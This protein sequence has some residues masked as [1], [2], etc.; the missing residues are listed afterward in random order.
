MVS[1]VEE[2][3]EE[4]DVP[5]HLAR[6]AV[7]GVDDEGD[8]AQAQQEGRDQTEEGR[9]RHHRGAPGGRGRRRGPPPGRPPGAGGGGG[10]GAG[11]PRPCRQ[12]RHR[13]QTKAAPITGIVTS[14]TIG[15]SRSICAMFHMISVVNAR[16]Q[17]SARR[18]RT[19]KSGR[20]RGRGGLG[21]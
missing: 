7:R 6:G 21:G 15:G 9:R 4:G 1:L 2:A 8:V 13:C 20:S 19:R 5:T 18:P 17:T 11:A 10:G 12:R 3:V 14:S 16:E